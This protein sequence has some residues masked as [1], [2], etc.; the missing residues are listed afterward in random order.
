MRCGAG[1]LAR[2]AMPCFDKTTRIETIL[3]IAY[4]SDSDTSGGIAG[5]HIATLR[6]DHR[7][8]R[9]LPARR[10]SGTN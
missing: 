7:A 9:M 2:P 4:R 10:P 3:P 8:S 1:V 6:A 5:D